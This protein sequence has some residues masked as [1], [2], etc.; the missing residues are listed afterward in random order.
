MKTFAA[1]LCIAATALTLAACDSTATGEV[2]TAVPYT[3]ERTAGY[4]N[5]PAPAPRQ[6]RVFRDVQTK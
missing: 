6:E 1:T 3:S 2:D 5:S 4:D